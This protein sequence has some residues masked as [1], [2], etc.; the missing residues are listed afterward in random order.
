[1]C[2][3]DKQR[4]NEV[5]DT[6]NRIILSSHSLLQLESAERLVDLFKRQITSPELNEK[7]EI[8]FLRKAESLHYFD[9]KKFRECGQDAA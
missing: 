6:V 4:I 3:M 9:W 8:I 1:M 7:L 2:V 5:F